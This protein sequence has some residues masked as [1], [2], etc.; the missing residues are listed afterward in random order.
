VSAPAEPSAQVP[1]ADAGPSSAPATSKTNREEKPKEQSTTPKVAKHDKKEENK[2]ESSTTASAPA[3]APKVAAPPPTNPW[4]TRKPALA[5]PAVINAAST[6][7]DAKPSTR[8][9]FG[10]LSPTSEAANPLPNGHANGH[11]EEPVKIGG[12]KKKKDS[13][14]A[15][16]MM[17]ANQWPDVA[18]AQV[19]GQKHEPKKEVKSEDVVEE[20][21]NTSKCQRV[22]RAG[23]RLTC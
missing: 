9:H 13:P 4:N 15:A 10:Q 21:Q 11:A 7:S 5:S 16:V 19:V 6:S 17:D 3:P 12:K 18:T 20:A 23:N 22:S 14:G 1:Q 2:A 8:L